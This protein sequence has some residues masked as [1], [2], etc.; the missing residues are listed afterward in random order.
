MM[1][2]VCIPTQ[3]RGNEEQLELAKQSG[4]DFYELSTIEGELREFRA[5]AAAHSK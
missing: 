2:M 5:I 3:E 4:S 1:S